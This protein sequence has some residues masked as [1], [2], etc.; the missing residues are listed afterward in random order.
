M[1]FVSFLSQIRSGAEQGG[2]HQRKAQNGADP[3]RAGAQSTGKSPHQAVGLHLLLH[4]LGQ[5]VSKAGEGNGG[6]ALGKV[7]QGAV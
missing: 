7:G 2:E 1:R 3:R 4:A 6:A 5:A